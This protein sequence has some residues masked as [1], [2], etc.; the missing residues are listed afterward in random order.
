MA[1]VVATAEPTPSPSPVV[2]QS[3]QASGR[4]QL[5]NGSGTPGL[6]LKARDVLQGAGFQVVTTANASK[7]YNKTTVFFQPGFQDMARAAAKLVHSSTILPAVSNLDKSI[8]V[9]VVV[10]VDYKP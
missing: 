4:L 9:T 2:E 7:K 8:P 6:A 1:S 5:L 3:P 10:G